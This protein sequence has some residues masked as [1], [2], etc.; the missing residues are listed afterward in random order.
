[1]DPNQASGWQR[2]RSSICSKS[3]IILIFMRR[4]IALP[5]QS[6]YI[7]CNNPFGNFQVF[8]AV[9]GPGRENSSS[10]P[11]S[12]CGAHPGSPHP[13]LALTGSGNPDSFP[14]MRPEVFCLGAIN[15]DLTFRVADLDGLLQRWG[16]GLARGGEEALSR[17]EEHRLRELLARFW[18]AGRA[19]PR[20]PG[21]QH[22]LCPGPLGIPAALAGRL[23]ADRT[24]LF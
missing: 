19:H 3:R 20:R 9:F 23:G 2:Q 5:R 16:T 6:P 22:R 12:G 10:Y 24:A 13:P 8:P 18:P 14:G 4:C 15:L 17:A 21:G 7:E 1:M 11:K